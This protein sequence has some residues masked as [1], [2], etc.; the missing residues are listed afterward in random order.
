MKQEIDELDSS[1]SKRG[2][3]ISKLQE[4]LESSSKE[5]EQNSQTLQ[6]RISN[7]QLEK[8]QVLETS[9][10]QESRANEQLASL[11]QSVDS[12]NLK[13]DACSKNVTDYHSKCN[14]KLQ[15]QYNKIS[16]TVH[17]RDTCETSLSAV[18]QEN[19][20]CILKYKE[21]LTLIKSMRDSNLN[22]ND[23]NALQRGIN[24]A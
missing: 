4:K 14:E 18:K 1:F 17:A 22:Q 9:R 21:A 2:L 8:D 5:C 16:E 11:A 19:D 15:E 24:L 6:A 13:L 12:L 7:L 20:Q 3:V 10:T 23:P